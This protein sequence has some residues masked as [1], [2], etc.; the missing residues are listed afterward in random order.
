MALQYTVAASRSSKHHHTSAHRLGASQVDDFR[1]T[2]AVLLLLSALPAVV[3]VRD[4]R[5]TADRTPP[6]QRLRCA[7]ARRFTCDT[8][9][10]RCVRGGARKQL[11][12]VDASIR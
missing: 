10:V 7:P 11:Q 12:T 2:V 4:A 6:L 1:A 8:P 3:G 5:P 9:T